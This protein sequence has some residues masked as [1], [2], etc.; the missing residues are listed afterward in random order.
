MMAAGLKPPPGGSCKLSQ[1]YT[2]VTTGYIYCRAS[3]KYSWQLPEGH[4]QQEATRFGSSLF[5]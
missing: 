1:Q 5:A 2:C 3:S 4:M